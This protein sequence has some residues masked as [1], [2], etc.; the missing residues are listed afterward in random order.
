[1]RPSISQVDFLDDASLVFKLRKFSSQFSNRKKTGRK[2]KCTPVDQVLFTSSLH[3]IWRKD[4]NKYV[5]WCELQQW[6]GLTEVITCITSTLINMLRPSPAAHL[7]KPVPG[8]QQVEGGGRSLTPLTGQQETE[9]C[10]LTGQQETELCPLT[11]VTSWNIS[12]RNWT[13]GRGLVRFN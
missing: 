2:H 10:P 9:L 6:C 7:V 5:W 1:M 3:H 11:T 8:P 12:L 13:V 4:S